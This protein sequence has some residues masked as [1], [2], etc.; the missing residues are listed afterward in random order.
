[1]ARHTSYADIKE[2]IAWQGSSV[3]WSVV[4]MLQACGFDHWSGH[5]GKWTSE[6]MS[7]WDNKVISLS[8]THP[9][10]YIHTYI[11]MHIYTQLLKNE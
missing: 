10:A 8:L 5:M 7:E 9:N 6:R 4:P 11:H 3:G 2:E 1:M